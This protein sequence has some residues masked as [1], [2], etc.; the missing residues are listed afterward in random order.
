RVLAE[1][2]FYPLY[3]QPIEIQIKSYEKKLPEIVFTGSLILQ[4]SLFRNEGLEHL[5][6]SIKDFDKRMKELE[7]RIDMYNS[8]LKSF[9]D[10]RLKDDVTSH[11][12]KSGFRLTSDKDNAQLIA[13]DTSILLP[14]IVLYWHGDKTDVVVIDNSENSVRIP[15]GMGHGEIAKVNNDDEKNKIRDLI[16]ELKDLDSIKTELNK[17]YGEISDICNLSDKL[18]EDIGINLIKHIELGNYDKTCKLCNVP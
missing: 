2:I 7:N 10:I 17:F 12:H 13:I 11:I 16:Q 4:N 3:K 6:K 15:S 5:Q 9:Y 8:D 18:S 14:E 1:K